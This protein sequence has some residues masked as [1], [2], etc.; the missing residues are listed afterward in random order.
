MHVTILINSSRHCISLS[1]DI[2]KNK[3]QRNKETH[4]R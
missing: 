3:E 1:R 4:K 2:I